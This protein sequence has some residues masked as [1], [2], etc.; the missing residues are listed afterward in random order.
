MAQLIRTLLLVLI[1]SPLFHSHLFTHAASTSSP[2]TRPRIT[3]INGLGSEADYSDDDEEDNGPVTEAPSSK[4]MPT[5]RR[6]PQ[7][8]KTDSCLEDQEPCSQLA[9]K[10]NCL[11]PGVSGAD[12]P[13]HPPV[14]QALLP[15]SQGADRGKV[16]VQWCAP[17]SVVSGYKVVIERSE[18]DALEFG[19][20]L[21]RGLVGSLEPGT[22][23]CVEATNSAGTSSPSE[24]SCARY[25]PP[26]TSDH[27]LLVWIIGGGVG[28]LLLIIITAVVLWKHKICQKG[29][30][31]S[32]DGLGNP[33][34]STE[35]TL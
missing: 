33:S 15:V 17:S 21:R 31:D 4:R 24:F 12:Q 19:D 3:Y 29:K 35:G 11:C 1:T 22:R 5:L 20:A 8:C 25:D 13:P 23:V 30:R 14:L 16:E 27:N 28:L 26:K 10:T 2:V 7:L 32:T 34:Y 18:A 9:E 6:P